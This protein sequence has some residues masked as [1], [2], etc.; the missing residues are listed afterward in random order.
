MKLDLSISIL[1]HKGVYL[2]LEGG[3]TGFVATEAS[4]STV[5]HII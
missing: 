2:M 4:K 1:C 5:A 3:G